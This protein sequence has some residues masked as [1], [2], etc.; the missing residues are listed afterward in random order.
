METFRT[1][2]STL[3]STSS[4][5]DGNYLGQFQGTLLWALIAG[6]IVAFLLSAGIGANDVANTFGTSVG[7]G[8]ITLKNACIVA[9]IFEMLGAILV[10]KGKKFISIMY[11]LLGLQVYDSIITTAGISVKKRS[12]FSKCR[13]RGIF[14]SEEI[15]AGR[16]LL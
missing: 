16:H 1:T 4:V 3:V 15:G 14:F 7:A 10:G 9:T 6:F 5:V 8:V 11:A 13:E 2:A 12:N